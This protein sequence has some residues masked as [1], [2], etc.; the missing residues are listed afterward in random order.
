MDELLKDVSLA[1]IIKLK[2]GSYQAFAVKLGWSKQKLQY[3]ITNPASISLAD[4]QEMADA[5]GVKL[6][7]DLIHIFLRT[8]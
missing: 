1:D 4:A 2:Y 7:E 5:L 8:G 6:N 3:K